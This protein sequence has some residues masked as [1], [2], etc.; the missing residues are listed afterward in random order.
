MKAPVALVTVVSY[1]QREITV[2]GAVRVPGSFSLSHG[3][4]SIGLT[5]LVTKAGGL[6]PLAK[7]DSILVTHRTS[8][9]KET[10][11]TVNFEKISSDRGNAGRASNEVTVYSGD[12]IFV[13]ERW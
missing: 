10:T 9:G 11:L 1:G 12:R 2:L 6:T 7:T 3:S 8:D 5:E 4:P 13:P